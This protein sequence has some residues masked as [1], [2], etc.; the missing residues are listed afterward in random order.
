VPV[1]VA[2]GTDDPLTAPDVTRAAVDRA[3]ALGGTV[4]L[5]EYDG[6]DHLTVVE[7][8]MPDAL[9]WVAGRFA[10]APPASTC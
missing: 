1:F 3:C 5:R 2:Q 8:S 10:A 4:E 6:A 9:A 7:E